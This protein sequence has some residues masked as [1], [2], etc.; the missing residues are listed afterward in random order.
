MTVTVASMPNLRDVGG[1]RTRG[2]ATLRTG[3][4]YRSDQ[5]PALPADDVRALARLGLRYVYDLRTEAE[6]A[7][8][9]GDRVP[10][11]TYVPLDVLADDRQS[12]AARLVR[13]LVDPG[14]AESLLGEGRGVAM[15]VASYRSFVELPSAQVA[16]RR[17]FEGLAEAGRLPALLHCTTGKDRTG[18]ACASLQLLL[19]VPHDEV[20]QDYLESNRRI[21]QK[22]ASHVAA[23]AAQGGDPALLEP[24]LGVREEYLDA[25]IEA[26]V[27]AHGS[28][29]G[30]FRRGLG[31]D[32]ALLDALK[33]RFLA[34]R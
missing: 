4:L 31:L 1:R 16:F 5:I 34:D 10:G 9:P 21:L 32:D 20:V 23:F 29:E 30:Y 12:M 6:R 14:S 24:V 2:G 3:L 26:A 25:S 18:W 33:E 11:A 28:I 17:L 19:G 8:L 7:M 15:F 13:L 22:Y 27:R